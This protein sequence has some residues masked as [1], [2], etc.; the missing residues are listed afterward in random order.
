M[1]QNTKNG[2]TR[3]IVAASIAAD[4]KVLAPFLVMKGKNCF[5]LINVMIHFLTFFHKRKP[6]GCIKHLF[7]KIPNGAHYTIQKNALMDECLMIEWIHMV[8]KPWADE[9]PKNIFQL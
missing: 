3:V 8:F 9:A 6:R 7:T 5:C 4:G 1:M 2:Y